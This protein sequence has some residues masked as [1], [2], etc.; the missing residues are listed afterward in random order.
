MNV[1][2]R[3]GNRRLVDDEAGAVTIGLRTVVMLVA[4]ITGVG[5]FYA[6]TAIKVQGIQFDLSRELD[7]QREQQE[8]GRRL[9]VEMNTLRAPERLE[10]EGERQGLATPKPDQLRGLK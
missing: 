2:L 7:N 1:S 8:V 5:I 10:R 9:K 4:L 6:Y 3:M